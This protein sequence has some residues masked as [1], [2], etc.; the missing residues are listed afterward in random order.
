MHQTTFKIICDG[1]PVGE[2]QGDLLSQEAAITAIKDFARSRA[3]NYLHL[4][5]RR[6]EANECNR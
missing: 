2:V 3:I 1:F 5:L 4:R 6:V